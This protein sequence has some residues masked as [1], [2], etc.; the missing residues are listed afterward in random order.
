M[1]NLLRQN[2][3]MYKRA[4]RP[5]ALLLLLINILIWNSQA[6]ATEKHF[7]IREIVK[8]TEAVEVDAETIVANISNSLEFLRGKFDDRSMYDKA[9]LVRIAADVPY[10]LGDSKARDRARTNRKL[11]LERFSKSGMPS[12]F[13]GSTL[14][15]LSAG[16]MGLPIDQNGL[17]KY[18]SDLSNDKQIRFAAL[19]AVQKQSH[20]SLT[21]RDDLL[22]LKKDDWNFPDPND[23]E[24]R[25]EA[26]I[27]PFRNLATTMLA[28]LKKQNHKDVDLPKN[29]GS[30]VFKN[31]NGKA[32]NQSQPENSL[33]VGPEENAKP[34][35]ASD[36]QAPKEKASSIAMW[37]IIVLSVLAAFVFLWL[38]SKR[39]D[40]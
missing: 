27:Y 36:E 35:A 11:V 5:I 19:D 15:Y 1:I 38:R 16:L 34:K 31:E 33:N 29:S 17:V 25:S 7:T 3:F 9:L 13:D 24:P 4:W 37:V 40:Q 23:L 2:E 6:Q 32:A 39:R 30:G 28:Q 10:N 14:L 22:A 20:L 18:A 21:I 12:D 8:M 26:P